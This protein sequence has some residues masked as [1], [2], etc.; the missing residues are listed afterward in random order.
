MLIKR[1]LD[2][3]CLRAGIYALE[4]ENGSITETEPFVHVVL[5]AL[6]ADSDSALPDLYKNLSDDQQRLANTLFSASTYF[7]HISHRRSGSQRYHIHSHRLDARIRSLVHWA[8]EHRDQ[9][10]GFTESLFGAQVLACWS[11]R[12]PTPAFTDVRT[13]GTAIHGLLQR[14]VVPDCQ[15]LCALIS[16]AVRTQQASVVLPI[17]ASQAYPQRIPPDVLIRLVSVRDSLGKA[18][19]RLHFDVL[20]SLIR[21]NNG[22]H[23]PMLVAVG[24]QDQLTF[25]FVLK[26]WAKYHPEDWR[27]IQALVNA[28]LQSTTSKILHSTHHLAIVSMLGAFRHLKGSAPNA[29]AVLLAGL[30][31][32]RKLLPRLESQSLP[33]M[34]QLIR[35]LTASEYSNLAYN[36]Y[37]AAARQLSPLATEPLVAALAEYFARREDMRSIMHLVS[38]V[39]RQDVRV[40]LHFYS[41]VITGLL[42]TRTPSRGRLTMAEAMLKS[43]RWNQ[44]RIPPKVLHSLMHGWA[45]IGRYGELG[46]A[47][48]SVYESR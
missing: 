5:A 8:Y 42:S 40:S 15:A 46:N 14:R 23:H 13:A 7:Y 6:V 33:A 37:R 38:M 2:A 29:S 31:I 4:Q 27:S 10:S 18:Y 47:D 30:R 36:M 26:Q 20:G 16:S 19:P 41:A 12:R 11:L 21:A 9:L 39:T 1:K 22:I 43:M 32:H 24:L 35:A 17:Y 45:D 28:M 3:E 48:A 44:I 34:H 25:H